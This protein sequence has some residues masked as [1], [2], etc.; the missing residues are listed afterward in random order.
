MEIIEDIGRHEV[1]KSW[2]ESS[3]YVTGPPNYVNI[4][5]GRVVFLVTKKPLLYRIQG[6]VKKKKQKEKLRFLTVSQ[7]L[8]TTQKHNP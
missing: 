5:N 8:S 3:Y 4:C 1:T 7:Y 2:C 6:A